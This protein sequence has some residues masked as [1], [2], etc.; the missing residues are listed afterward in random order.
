[1]LWISWLNLARQA[2]EG[3]RRP[4]GWLSL[5]PTGPAFQG[6]SR[7]SPPRGARPPHQSQRST[8]AV[9]TG[10]A[11]PGLRGEVP[12]R[13]LLPEGTGAPHARPRPPRGAVLV[14]V[15]AARVPLPLETPPRRPALVWER[16]S[17]TSSLTASPPSG[18]NE[19]VQGS[20]RGRAK[21]FEPR[22]SPRVVW[23]LTEQTRLLG[24]ARPPRRADPTDAAAQSSSPR[25]TTGVS[26]RAGACLSSEHC[27]LVFK[28]K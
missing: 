23:D 9:Q 11:S 17:V 8:G 3:R 16:G 4:A 2:A 13:P 28:E 22:G 26:G 27:L 24:A 20:A 6:R 10:P 19:E 18:A 5:S 7:R 21:H 25:H 12:L 1:M 14:A 15:R